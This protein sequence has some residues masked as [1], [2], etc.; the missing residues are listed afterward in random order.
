MNLIDSLKEKIQNMEITEHI[1]NFDIHKLIDSVKGF[2]QNKKLDFSGNAWIVL[3]GIFAGIVLILIFKILFNRSYVI[4]Q[5]LANYR[6][7]K[8][9]R[10][11]YVVIRDYRKGRKRKNR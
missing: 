8:I 4:R 2:F 1:Q 7:R 11:K 3:G 10:K 6:N 5:K 9:E